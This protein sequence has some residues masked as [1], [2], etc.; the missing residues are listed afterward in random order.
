MGR[1]GEGRH[2]TAAGAAPPAPA[3]SI[4]SAVAAAELFWK[5]QQQVAATVSG[6]EVGALGGLLSFQSPGQLRGLN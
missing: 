4:A 1:S 5:L 2:C 6:L 3:I